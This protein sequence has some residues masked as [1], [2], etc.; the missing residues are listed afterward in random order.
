MIRCFEL[1]QLSDSE[2]SP[3]ALQ[4]SLER[5]YHSIISSLRVRVFYV[6]ERGSFGLAVHGIMEGEAWQNEEYIAEDILVV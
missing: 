6:T 5:M 3:E 2:Q 1:L 4:D